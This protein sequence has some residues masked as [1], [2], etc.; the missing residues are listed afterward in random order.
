MGAFLKNGIIM[1]GLSAACGVKIRISPYLL[2]DP[3]T[4]GD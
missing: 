4:S 1:F 3:Y 2:L